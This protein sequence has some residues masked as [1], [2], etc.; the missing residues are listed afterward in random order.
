VSDEFSLF[1][2]NI[3]VENSMVRIAMHQFDTD[4]GHAEP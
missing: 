1:Y 2:A 3:A 4:T